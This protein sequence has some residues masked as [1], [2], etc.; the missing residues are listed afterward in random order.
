MV[1]TLLTAWREARDR[2]TAAGVDSPVLDARLLLERAT[3][4]RRTEILT[5]P[6]RKLS[7][8][9]VVTLDALLQRREAREP[10]SHI[11]GVKAFWT[12]ELEVTPD[13][14]TPR[15]ETE[16]LVQAAL[17]HLPQAAPARAL[18]LGVGSG[19]ILLAV[20]KERPAARGVGLDCSAAA[21]AVA[22]KNASRLGLAER[23][24]WKQGDFLAAP[25]GPFD[26]I[27]SNPPYIPSGDLAGLE[28]EVSQ[29]EPRLALDG[30][31]DG[32]DAYR[33]IAPL[34]APRLTE[35]G[36]ALLEV[37]AGQAPSVQALLQA[38]AL[39]VQE[40]RKDLAGHGRVIVARR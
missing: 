2:L 35:E 9:E 10:V 32:L 4:V 15:P 22:R 29:F 30:G 17:E 33:A 7:D 24:N 37:G 3:G 40:V 5:D 28:P 39:T 11:L 18:D 23:V 1:E 21:L 25:N 19:A 38:A 20:L 27:V 31:A 6:Y 16:F 36:R 8:V 26:L 14:L 34:L 12:F 13:V